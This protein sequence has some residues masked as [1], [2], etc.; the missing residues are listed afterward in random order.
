[1]PEGDT[2]DVYVPSAAAYKGA[3]STG[4]RERELRPLF[5]PPTLSSEAQQM[6]SSSSC[7]CS[8][9]FMCWWKRVK[10]S[11]Y[12]W[13]E[14]PEEFIRIHVVPRQ[15]FFVP[16]LWS[17]RLTGLKDLLM[18]RL[19]GTRTT[20]A[21][22]C[23]SDGVLV[24]TQSSGN[25]VEGTFLDNVWIG[26][27]RFSK[28]KVGTCFLSTATDGHSS[29]VDADCLAME[30]EEIAAPGGVGRTWSHGTSQLD[31]ARTEVHPGGT[32]PIG[33]TPQGRRQ[34]ERPHQDDV[35]S[36]GRRGQEGGHSDAGQ[37]HTGIDDATPARCEDHP[38]L[39]H[40]PVRPL[41]GLD[42][43]EGASS[44]PPMGHQG[45]QERSQ[46]TRGSGAPCHVGKPGDGATGCRPGVC[47]EEG[48]RPRS[49]SAGGGASALNGV[50][51]RARQLFRGILGQGVHLQSGLSE[52]KAENLPV[53]TDIAEEWVEDDAE[54]IRA[55]ENQLAALKKKQNSPKKCRMRGSKSSMKVETKMSAY[56]RR[57]WEKGD[58]GGGL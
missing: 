49:R 39:H 33:A 42:V 13:I 45:D 53:D 47:E 27:S 12:F 11:R 2:S 52:V 25:E 1:M 6:L 37:A 3:Q 48:R 57:S 40:R 55:L 8:A 32:T 43:S 54:R 29:S 4:E 38:G 28:I 5:Y 7:L 26:R 31:C 15:T 14:T 23:L 44:I 22:L 46:C 35:G 19:D 20:E 18:K 10:K 16:S 58:C 34:D 56:G 51:E 9:S 50:G 41:Q 36:A 24:N 21:L 17:T 30:H